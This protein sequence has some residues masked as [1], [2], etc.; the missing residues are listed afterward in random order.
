M[1][2]E[3]LSPLLPP[4]RPRTGRPAR[5]HRTILSAIPWVLRTGAPWRD[6]P[7][8]FGPW[9]TAWSRFR[10]W[11]AA[12]VWARVLAVLQQQADVAGQLDRDTHYM[13]GSVVRAHG[14][15]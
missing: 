15:A 8:R 7:E 2:C 11:T 1:Q 10:R 13:D 6:P 12:G 9:A 5:G 4:Q 14:G 3:R